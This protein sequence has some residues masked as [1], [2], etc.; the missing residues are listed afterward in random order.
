MNI[1]EIKEDEVFELDIH[2]MNRREAE[3]YLKLSLD[4]LSKKYKEVKVI[5]G[6]RRGK[7]LLELVRERFNH[8]KVDTKLININ[9]GL[10]SLFIKDEYLS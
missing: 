6:Y 2:N 9:P 7:V 10:T 1:L 3:F 8:P 5:H 4:N